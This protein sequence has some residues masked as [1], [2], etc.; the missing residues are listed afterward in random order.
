MNALREHVVFVTGG[1]RGLGQVLVESAARAG[2]SV[3]FTGRDA[4]ALDAVARTL[5]GLPVE[6]MVADVTDAEQ[7]SAAAARAAERFGTVDVLVNNAGV[8][9]PAGKPTWELDGDE[10]WAT[11]EINLRGCD[12]TTRAVLPVIL[13]AGGGRVINIVSK[14]GRLRWPFVSA[15]SVSKAA[16]I[17]LTENIARE[18]KS[19]NVKFFAYDPGL[20]DVG[21]GRAGFELAEKLAARGHTGTVAT[22]RFVDWASAAKASVTPLPVVEAQFRELCSGV[23]DEWAGGYVCADDLRGS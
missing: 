3:F 17:K 12:I 15:Y 14:A 18:A 2:A 8:G 11:L 6:S 21:I 20:L 16:V 13:A 1:S 19:R 10:W 22:N 4:A 23:H 9:G 5:H 7:M